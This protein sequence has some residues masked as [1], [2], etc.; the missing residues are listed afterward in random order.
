MA[1]YQSIG[2]QLAVGC[3]YCLSVKKI[4]GFIKQNRD[5]DCD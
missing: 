3:H 1:A 2:C 5:F 4:P